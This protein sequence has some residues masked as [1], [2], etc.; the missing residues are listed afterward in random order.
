MKKKFQKQNIKFKILNIGSGGDVET[1]L[2]NI[3]NVEL[4]NVDI[5][6]KRRPDKILD[7]TE[8]NFEIK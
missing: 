7:I 5:D 4:V 8:T 1:L 6:P 3:K 2:K